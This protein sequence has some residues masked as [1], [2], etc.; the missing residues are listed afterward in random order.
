MICQPCQE[1][2]HPRCEDAQRGESARY[3]SCYCQHKTEV[4][5]EPATGPAGE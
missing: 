5:P 2:D 3:S 4:Q 1:R